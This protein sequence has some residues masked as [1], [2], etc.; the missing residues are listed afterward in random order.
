LPPPRDD[1]DQSGR[2]EQHPWADKPAEIAE[3]EEE[4]AL[5]AV[6]M[7]PAGFE[8]AGGADDVRFSFRRVALAGWRHRAEQDADV[9]E[10]PVGPGEFEKGVDEDQ[11]QPADRLSWPSELATNSPAG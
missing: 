10:E 11:D 7:A 9:V 1:H 5:A 4:S 8:Q 6:E 2:H 3:R